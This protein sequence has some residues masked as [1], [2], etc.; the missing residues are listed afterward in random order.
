ML[1]ISREGQPA[2]WYG[3]CRKKMYSSKQLLFLYS[4]TSELVVFCSGVASCWN[5]VRTLCLS[6]SGRPAMSRNSCAAVC[7]RLISPLILCTRS[8]SFTGLLVN[9]R[10]LCTR[11][12]Q[13]VNRTADVLDHIRPCLIKWT[14][15]I[16]FLVATALTNMQRRRC[17]DDH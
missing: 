14:V 15:S 17:G 16:P 11:H 3:C 7:L 6:S 1:H 10:L 13:P 8:L 4:K 2:R 9:F 12:T 5:V